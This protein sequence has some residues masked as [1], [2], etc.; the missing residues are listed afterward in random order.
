MET[1]NDMANDREM[2]DMEKNIEEVKKQDNTCYEECL[3]YEYCCCCC[4][5]MCM[6]K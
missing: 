2:N 4:I 1:L 6:Y 5:F 3:F